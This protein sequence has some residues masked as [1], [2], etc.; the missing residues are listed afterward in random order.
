M[1]AGSCPVIGSYGGRDMMGVAAPL[2]QKAGFNRRRRF[3]QWAGL[4]WA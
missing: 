3:S 1:V 4:T 2:D